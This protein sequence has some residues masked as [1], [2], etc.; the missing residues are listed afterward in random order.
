MTG[1]QPYAF[2]WQGAV[3][4]NRAALLR[5]VAVLFV[6][7]GL[8]EGGAD[9]VPRRV[10]RMIL[11]LL[12]PAES[13]AR[14]LI[15]IAAR[16][17]EID[18][19]KPR[20]EKPLTGIERLVAAGVLTFHEVNLGLARMWR[21]E[22]AVPGKPAPAIPAFPLTDPPLRFDTR[23]WDGKRPFPR[24]GF[25]LADADEEVD[26]RH[27]CRRLAA[28]KH[29][30]DDLDTQAK[31][32]ARRMARANLA[33]RQMQGGFAPAVRSA[34]GTGRKA[35]GEP[36]NAFR[37]TNA[38]SDS[39]GPPPKLKGA[40][41]RQILRLGH[42]PGHRRQP[43]HAVDDVLRECHSLALHALKPPDTS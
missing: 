17:I 42:P 36:A 40:N 22:P 5:V 20:G 39:G 29:A 35:N 16:N 32:L 7:A 23:A 14:R 21:P 10:W 33:S 28:L 13:A 6:Y 26:A 25:E 41:R 8:D 37:A 30:L 11:R 19:P 27:L 34:P 43:S 31:R 4:R 24:D 15:V 38:R 3:A 2:D 9:E 1:T 18:P 12:R